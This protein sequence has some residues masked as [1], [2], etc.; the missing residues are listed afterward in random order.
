MLLQQIRYPSCIEQKAIYM[1]IC[2]TAMKDIEARLNTSSL[3]LNDMDADDL[4]RLFGP[5]KIS[6]EQKSRNIGQS[7]F[8]LLVQ[9]FILRNPSVEPPKKEK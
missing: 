7:E 8:E 5:R 4:H 2:S 3:K 1:P 6:P 9:Y